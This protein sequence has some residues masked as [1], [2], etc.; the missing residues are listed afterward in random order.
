MSSLYPEREYCVHYDESDLHFI[1][2]LWR[3]QYREERHTM[4]LAPDKPGGYPASQA[5]IQGQAAARLQIDPLLLLGAQDAAN[6]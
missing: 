5:T 1:Q 4:R 2:R 6:R 3:G